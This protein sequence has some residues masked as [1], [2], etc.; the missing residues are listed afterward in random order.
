MFQKNFISKK[1]LTTA[2]LTITCTSNNTLIYLQ[3]NKS[4]NGASSGTVGLK[5]SKRSTFFAA[6]QI[7]LYFIK[8]L[9]EKKIDSLI[10]IF[11]GFGRG[12]KAIIKELKKNNVKI[13]RIFDKTPIA[14]NGCRSSKKRRL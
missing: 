4:S 10:V 9:K 8:F 12:R 7:I 6:Q 1:I 5:G 11:K 2:V 3:S 14:H 13:L